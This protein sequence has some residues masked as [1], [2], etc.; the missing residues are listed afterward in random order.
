MKEYTFSKID[1][2]MEKEQAFLNQYDACVQM[3]GKKLFRLAI[4]DKVMIAMLVIISIVGLG[5]VLAYTMGI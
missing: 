1:L 5:T 4:R 3:S 2:L